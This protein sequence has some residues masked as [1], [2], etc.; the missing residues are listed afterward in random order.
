M[1]A[2]YSHDNLIRCKACSL[3]YDASDIQF[4]G[5]HHICKYCIKDLESNNVSSHSN[6]E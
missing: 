4:F 2:S 6:I 3:K 5:G 1:Y